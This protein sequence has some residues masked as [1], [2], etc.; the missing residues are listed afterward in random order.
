MHPSI[1]PHTPGTPGAQHAT[2][3]QASRRTWLLCAVAGG[4]AAAAGLGGVWQWRR[5]PPLPATHQATLP[6]AAPARTAPRGAALPPDD[7][8]LVAPPSPYDPASGLLPHA[9]RP[10]PADARCPV[11]GMFPARTPEWAAQLIFANGDAHFFDSP[12]SLFMY[13]QDL[14]RYSPARQREDVATI[15]VTDSTAPGG[16]TWTA[17]E[18]AWYVH[19]SSARG[20]MRA[21]NLPAFAHQGTAQAFADQRGGQVLAFVQVDATVV[22]RLAGR[23]GEGRPGEGHA[24]GPAPEHAAH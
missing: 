22:Q 10:V 23:S 5:R 11:C 3:P 21:G 16:G 4:V 20:P 15:Y 24:N 9:A 8:C 12:L 1:A 17:A 14:R 18:S 19:G 13:L 6:T 7:V 2:P